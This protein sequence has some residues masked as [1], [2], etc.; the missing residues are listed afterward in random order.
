M[1]CETLT[2]S[3]SAR[4]PYFLQVNGKFKNAMQLALSWGCSGLLCFGFLR[5]PRHRKLANVLHLFYILSLDLFPYERSDTIGEMPCYLN[6]G[7]DLQ[8]MTRND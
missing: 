5:E 8:E 1:F 4:G 3:A 7:S 2:R 6:C